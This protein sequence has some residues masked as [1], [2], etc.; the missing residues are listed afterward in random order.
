MAT[1][2]RE[3]HFWRRKLPMGFSLYLERLGRCVVRDQPKN[4]YEYAA[5]YMED[6][7]LEHEGNKVKNGVFKSVHGILVRTV[8]LEIFAKLR[9]CGVS[10]NKTIAK[11]KNSLSLTDAGYSCQI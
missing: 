6:L 3:R 5:Q 1:T 8:N 10:Q 4:I 9:R 7:V 11:R 2:E